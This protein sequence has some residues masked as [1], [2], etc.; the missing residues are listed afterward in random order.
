MRYSAS[1]EA[2]ASGEI[3]R[4][5]VLSGG[6]EDSIGGNFESPSGNHQLHYSWICSFYLHFLFL[7]MMDN[8]ASD[9]G[10]LKADGT[11]DMRFSENQ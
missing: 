9:D 5:Q 1:E 10:P 4:D 3:S 2:V 11:P 8:A 7:G 6:S